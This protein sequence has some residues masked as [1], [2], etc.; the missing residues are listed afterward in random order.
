MAGVLKSFLSGFVAL[1]TLRNGAALLL[2]ASGNGLGCN[3]GFVSGLPRRKPSSLCTSSATVLV[4]GA[5]GAL[6]QSLVR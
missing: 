2:K 3:A 5:N 1:W 4:T 6:G